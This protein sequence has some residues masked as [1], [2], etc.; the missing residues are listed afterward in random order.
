MCLKDALICRIL[1]HCTIS[2]W[3]MTLPVTGGHVGCRYSLTSL[4][5]WEIQPHFKLVLKLLPLTLIIFHPWHMPNTAILKHAWVSLVHY[6]KTKRR[7]T[8]K[9]SNSMNILQNVGMGLGCRD[10]VTT[11]ASWLHPFS[12]HAIYSTVTQRWRDEV[13]LMPFPWLQNEIHCSYTYFLWFWHGHL[14]I[15][16]KLE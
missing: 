8:K 9:T 11:H 5:V 6:C 12:G 1:F 15:P 3:K 14:Y 2:Q 10:T 4:G 13:T 7:H 16:L